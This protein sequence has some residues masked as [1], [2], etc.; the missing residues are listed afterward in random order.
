[1]EEKNSITGVSLEKNYW[2]NQTLEA[3][4]VNWKNKIGNNCKRV[5]AWRTMGRGK[6]REPLSFPSSPASFR[7]VSSQPVTKTV[8]RGEKRFH[9]LVYVSIRVSQSVSQYYNLPHR[10]TTDANFPPTNYMVVKIWTA[11]FPLVIKPFPDISSTKS[12]L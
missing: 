8:L 11:K 9:F 1:M 7:F 10:R 2:P 6:K 4:T 12:P 5:C 3:A